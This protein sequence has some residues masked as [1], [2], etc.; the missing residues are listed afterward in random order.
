M[1]DVV[2]LN[3]IMPAVGVTA[4]RVPPAVPGRFA[5][6]SFGKV[7]TAVPNIVFGFA[8]NSILLIL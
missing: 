5:V 1:Y 4:E 6:V 7:T 8:I 3:L 2:S